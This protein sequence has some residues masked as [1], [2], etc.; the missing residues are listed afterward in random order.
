MLPFVVSI[1]T[2]LERASLTTFL[3]L[4]LRAWLAPASPQ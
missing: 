3:S 2:G 4:A 1:L